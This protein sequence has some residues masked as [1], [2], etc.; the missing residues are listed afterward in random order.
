MY[1][2][3]V[4]Y[5]EKLERF[6]TGSTHNVAL[7]LERHNSDYYDD[8]W[9]AKGKPW[10]LFLEVE[11]GSRSQAESIE[12]HIKRMKSK[13]YIRNLAKYPEITEKL[14]AKYSVGEDC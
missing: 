11:C 2:V 9:T 1:Y 10:G 5:S 8:K 12:R 14:K 13:Q 7:R 3:Y 4:L 6:Y